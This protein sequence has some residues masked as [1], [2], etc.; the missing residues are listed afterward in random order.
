MLMGVGNLSTFNFPEGLLVSRCPFPREPC[1]SFQAL[2]KERGSPALPELT[3]PK[4]L[5][6]GDPDLAGLKP[7][8]ELWAIKH[9]CDEREWPHIA[10]G[11]VLIEC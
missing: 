1:R 9:R 6:V 8:F 5:G 2:L 11:E 10:P 7:H 3:S 4:Y